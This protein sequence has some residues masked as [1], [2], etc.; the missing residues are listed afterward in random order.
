MANLDIRDPERS[1]LIVCF[2][3]IQY[4]AG[5]AYNRTF[6]KGKWGSQPPR[7]RGREPQPV[8][9]TGY[10]DAGTPRQPED[11][12]VR[13]ARA[14]ESDTV[15]TACPRERPAIGA[16]R[17]GSASRPAWLEPRNE[18]RAGCAGQP[19]GTRTRRRSALAG[20]RRPV[21]PPHTHQPA[22]RSPRRPQPHDAPA[23]R[24]RF[25]TTMPQTN[26]AAP[27]CPPSAQAHGGER[28][29]PRRPKR[30]GRRRERKAGRSHVGGTRFGGDVMARWR[31]LRRQRAAFQ[32]PPNS[33]FGPRA[34]S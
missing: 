30:K 11:R 22:V 14:T 17:A 29:G 23:A 10:L 32:T 31:L 7:G 12:T 16:R 28:R 34:P 25:T 13:D 33:L 27:A 2:S 8:P 6:R 5:K 9:E 15:A 24:R 3:K 19:A 4:D 18:P 1:L 20:R 21:S 26:L